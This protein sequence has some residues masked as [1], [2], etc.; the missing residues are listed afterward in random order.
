MCHMWAGLLLTHFRLGQAAVEVH[1]PAA[2]L[3]PRRFILSGASQK[4]KQSLHQEDTVQKSRWEVFQEKRYMVNLSSEPS[5]RKCFL[6]IPSW[7]DTL[8]QCCFI[9]GPASR[10]WTNFKTTF[11]VS[12]VIYPRRPA[13]IDHSV[14][15]WLEVLGLNPGRFG[16]SHSVVHIQ[17]P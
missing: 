16:H 10:R 2:W 12:W 15:L 14:R 6:F 17:C 7:H 5:Q 3:K 1:S 8:H 4:S 11:R 9:T 13:L